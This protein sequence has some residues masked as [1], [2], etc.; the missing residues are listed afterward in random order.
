M[1]DL[2]V[3]A[4]SAVSRDLVRRAMGLSSEGGRMRPCDAMDGGGVDDVGSTLGSVTVVV[5]CGCIGFTLG[6]G[7]RIGAAGT[8][9]VDSGVGGVDTLGDCTSG[10]CCSVEKMAR[11][12]SIAR[13]WSSVFVGVR[14]A[15]MAVVRAR[16]QWMMRS[17][18]V[19]DGRV[20]V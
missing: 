14:S 13:S 10:G 15:C 6:D 17:S 12:L 7:A 3:V 19:N 11:R 8:P 18:V 16:R 20:R 5:D 4:V 9:V 1:T 2:V